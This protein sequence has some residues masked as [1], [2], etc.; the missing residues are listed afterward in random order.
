MATVGQWASDNHKY[1]FVKRDLFRCPGYDRLDGSAHIIGDRGFLFLFPTGTQ[2]N[3]H[4]P[5]NDDGLKAKLQA[6]PSVLRASIKIN[7]WLGL[8]VD[9]V[10]DYL[11][12]EVYPRQRI[13]GV[14]RYGDELLYDVLKNKAAIL[15]LTP[16]DS[17]APVTAKRPYDEQ[18]QEVH[19]SR[20]FWDDVYSPAE[21]LSL[22]N[23]DRAERILEREDMLCDR[24]KVNKING[25][26][27]EELEFKQAEAAQFVSQAVDLGDLQLKAPA[28]IAVWIRPDDIQDDRRVFGQLAGPTTQGGTLRLQKG[29]LQLWNGNAWHTLIAEGIAAGTWTHI[30]VVFEANGQASGYLNG[31]KRQS[32]LSRFDFVG[33]SVGI[34]A[35]FLNQHG[36]EF[37]GRMKDFQIRRQALTQ[38]E[39]SEL[40]QATP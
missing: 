24:K 23:E 11:I 35:R 33:T 7:H 12:S 26:A 4:T 21:F 31:Q 20:A 38:Q 17:S 19:L 36:N 30:A 8:D 15:S 29:Q 32:A 27:A 6:D 2:P 25:V 10:A 22:S 5:G 40:A 3:T 13:L 14:Y 28:T 39:I 18:A 9:E 1:L 16:H 34:G 37:L